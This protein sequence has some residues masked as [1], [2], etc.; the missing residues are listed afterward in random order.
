[1]IINH[2]CCCSSSIRRSGSRSEVEAVAAV[3]ALLLCQNLLVWEIS[4]TI[5]WTQ[6]ITDNII[7]KEIMPA[8]LYYVFIHA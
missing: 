3:V 4:H 8:K 5:T 7:Y 2:D 6:I 1:M